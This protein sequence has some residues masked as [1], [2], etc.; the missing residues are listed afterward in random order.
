MIIWEAVR[1]G[2]G[3]TQSVKR[4]VTGLTVLESNIG[5]ARFSAHY[6][7]GPGTQPASYTV[8]IGSFLGV[9]RPGRGVDHSPH[10]A[11]QLRKE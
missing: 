6:P 4:L 7:T 10:L 9:K 2:A 11:L 3:I 8:G 5:G 1:K